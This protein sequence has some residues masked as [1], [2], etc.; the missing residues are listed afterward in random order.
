MS[1][2]LQL[3]KYLWNSICSQMTSILIRFLVLF[4]LHRHAYGCGSILYEL[5]LTSTKNASNMDFCS[6]SKC[7][8]GILELGVIH[9]WISRVG[10]GSA[11]FRSNT[12]I[13]SF[14]GLQQ[15]LESAFRISTC[16]VVPTRNSALR[17][18]LTQ[19]LLA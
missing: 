13:D 3:S 14:M 9:Y 7:S 6:Y 1:K 5:Y 15:H 12:Q 19:G 18:H 2:D 11:T 17:L 16:A 10:N 4:P 8:Q